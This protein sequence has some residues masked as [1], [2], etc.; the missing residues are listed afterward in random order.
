MRTAL[1][2]DDDARAHAGRAA[3]IE[4]FAWENS[5]R[6]MLAAYEMALGKS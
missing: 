1:R 5:A 2:G 6:E 4:R 3:A